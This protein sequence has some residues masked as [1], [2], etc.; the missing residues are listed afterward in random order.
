MTRS[1][2]KPWKPSWYSYARCSAPRQKSLTALRRAAAQKLAD[3]VSEE[4]TALAMPNASLV[5]EV[6]EAEK[7]SVHGR[8]TVPHAGAAPNRRAAPAR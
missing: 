6:A 1:D 5:V 3:A 8:D 7:F 4:L 2:R